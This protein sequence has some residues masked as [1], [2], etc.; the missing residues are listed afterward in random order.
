MNNCSECHRLKSLLQ[1]L[2]QSAEQTA[3]EQHQH[4]ELMVDHLSMVS[5]QHSK[6][7]QEIKKRLDLCVDSLDYLV[8]CAVNPFSPKVAAA[9]T[10]VLHERM[11]K[12]SVK[13]AS[14]WN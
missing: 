13:G 5:Q 6:E 9:K 7:I 2:A 10:L 1:S 12:F 11:R 4:V 3:F 8:S 14:Q